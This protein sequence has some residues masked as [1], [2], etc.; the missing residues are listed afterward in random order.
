MFV[1]VYSCLWNAFCFDLIRFEGIFNLNALLVHWTVCLVRLTLDA[2]KA[3][4][5]R[6]DIDSAY[7]LSQ[8]YFIP[9]QM[10]YPCHIQSILTYLNHVSII[11]ASELKI[12]FL[13]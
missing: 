2:T 13:L 8:K 10:I 5:Q 3:S 11:K 1:D 12:C 6:P 7:F 4:I 9:F